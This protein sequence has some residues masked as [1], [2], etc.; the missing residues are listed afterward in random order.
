MASFAMDYLTRAGAYDGVRSLDSNVKSKIVTQLFN[1]S[2]PC[3]R[4]MS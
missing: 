2:R 4:W 3:L 1:R